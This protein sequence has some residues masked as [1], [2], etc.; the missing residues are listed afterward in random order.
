M[1]G[2][3][4]GRRIT[5]EKGVLMK[6][7][8]IATDGSDGAQ[9]AVEEGVLLAAETGAEV[10]FVT[11]RPHESA[12]LGDRLYQQHLTEHLASAHAA[13]DAAEAEA[14]RAGVDFDSDILEGDP[15]ERI[16][17]AVRG[18]G[19]DLV[20]VGSRGHGAVTSAMF[21]SVSRALLS[22]SPV[23]VMVVRTAT[24]TGVAA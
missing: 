12:L 6:R 15:A 4:P 19:A 1:A 18:W 3:A 16:A 21:G 11:V 10:T 14:R 24:R 17:Q 7:I 8:L 5:L 13:L 9:A 22:R 2:A 20:V 23:P